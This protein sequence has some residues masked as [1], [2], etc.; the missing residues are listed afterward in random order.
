[1]VD[2]VSDDRIDFVYNLL[3][4]VEVELRIIQCDDQFRIAAVQS[5]IDCCFDLQMY[6]LDVSIEHFVFIELSHELSLAVDVE[7]WAPFFNFSKS[8][9]VET[10]F[11]F[12][13]RFLDLRFSFLHCPA[14]NK[15]NFWQN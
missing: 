14:H 9:L 13:L 5:F 10:F 7:F 3:V 15:Q 11:N 6:T 1:V 2:L 8:N 12:C 4:R